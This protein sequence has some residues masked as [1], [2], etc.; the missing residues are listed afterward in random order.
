MPQQVP[1]T[2]Q[3]HHAMGIVGVVA[4]PT[5]G[6][7]RGSRHGLELG[8]PGAGA[9][10]AAAQV[11]NKARAH[12]HTHTPTCFAMPESKTSRL[13]ILVTAPFAHHTTPHQEARRC[14]ATIPLP[15]TPTQCGNV[16]QAFHCPMPPG[17]AWY[18]GCS[19]AHCPH[20]VW[21]SSA[22]VPLPGAPRPCG[23]ISHDFYCSLLPRG[24]S[25]RYRSYIARCPRAERW[26]IARVP[27]SAAPC[28]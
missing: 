26:H 15:S 9:H 6:A 18:C 5:G 19:T 20:V 16:L 4:T 24:V 7:T 22:G 17:V 8:V 14:I 21:Q 10:V 1:S 2:P 25:L 28:L 3:G 23:S 13:C 12:T 11:Q 27:P